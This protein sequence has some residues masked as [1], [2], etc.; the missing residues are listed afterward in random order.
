[1]VFGILVTIS[2][3]AG[4][5]LDKLY[6]HNICLL[7]GISG[8]IFTASS[9]IGG[10]STALFRLLSLK[11]L[12][13][14]ISESKKILRNLIFME[15]VLGSTILILMVVPFILHFDNIVIAETCTWQ[16]EHLLNIIA[17]H[18]YGYLTKY[19]LKSIY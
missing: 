5:P 17:V 1:M 16:S 15:V 10:L 9:F 11:N 3:T 13:V 8:A 18:K 4:K 19:S 7:Y 6:G 12:V 14:G 2:A